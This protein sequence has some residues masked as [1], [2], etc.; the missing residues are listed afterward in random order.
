MEVLRERQFDQLR[1]N[2]TV[3]GYLMRTTSPSDLT[4]YRDGG[5][6][7]TFL[8]V[9]CHL[10]DYDTIFLERVQLIMAQEYPDIPRPDPD[11]LAAKRRYNEQEP[12]VVYDDWVERREQ[13][14]SYLGTLKG[15]DWEQAGDYPRRGRYSIND[16]LITAA[17]H[18]TNHIEQMVR[19]LDEKQGA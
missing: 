18:D 10:R 13:F 14:L 6:G 3:I 17:W 15:D 7:W 19:I 5:E 16:V 1:K 2:P 9:L 12:Q 11:E 4:L 8:E